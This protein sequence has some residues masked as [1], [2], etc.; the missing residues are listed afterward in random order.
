MTEKEFIKKW[1]TEIGEL[2]KE[3]PEGF[4]DN[5]H[6][7]KLKMFHTDFPSSYFS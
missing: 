4:I 2:L 5:T 6:V 1:V 7:E 3:F